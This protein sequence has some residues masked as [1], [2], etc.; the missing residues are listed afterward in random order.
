MIN[1]KFAEIVKNTE[2]EVIYVITNKDE[3]FLNAL[4]VLPG[5]RPINQAK[6]NKLVEA[7]KKGEF[8]PPIIVSLPHRFVTEGNH[9][10]TAAKICLESGIPFKLLVYCYKDEN[11]LSTARVINNTQKRWTADDRLKSYCYE[12]KESYKL[13][14]SFMDSYPEYFLKKNGAY[15]ISAALCLLAGDRGATSMNVSFYK[16]ILKVTDAHMKFAEEILKELI[17]IS[18]ILGT[19]APLSRGNSTGWI[20]ARTRLGMP[21][22]QFMNLLKK[23]AKNW[24]QPKD[25]ASAWMQMY[26]R[27]SA[28]L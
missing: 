5:N 24:V 17:L 7:F 13:L 9:R 16:G 22:P 3:E 23:N 21:I 1:S 8:I 4:N 15:N 26:I 25:S 11:A 6:V 2:K 14:K 12:G 18:T 20:K 19:N 27:I 10:T 28:G